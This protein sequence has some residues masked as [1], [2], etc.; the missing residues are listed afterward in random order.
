[1]PAGLPAGTSPDTTSDLAEGIAVIGMAGRFPGAP[2]LAAFWHNLRTGVESVRRLDASE[3]EESPFAPRLRAHPDFV[4]AGGILEGADLFDHG[5]FGLSP[6]EARLTDPQQRVF[7][8]LAWA[9]LEDAGIDPGRSGDRISVYA[10]ASHSGHL[11]GLLGELGGAPPHGPQPAGPA[12]LDPAALY[13]AMNNATAEN[14]ATRVAFELRLRGEAV[15]LYTACSTGLAVV[16]AACQSLLLGQ[17][18]VALAGAVRIAVPQ[19]TGYA[20]QEGMILSRD[21]HCRAFDA[22]ASGTV[23]GNGAGVVVLKPVEAALAAGDH[24]Y[25]VIKATAINNDGHRGIGFTAPSVAGQA[26]VISEAMAFAGVTGDDIGYVEAHGTGTPLGDPIEIAA[27]TRA[28]RTGSARTA[29]CPI[30]TVKSNVGH[31]DTAAG[32]AGLIKVALMLHHGEIPPT[33]HVR[34]PN[35]AAGFTGSP[36]FPVTDLRPWPAGKPRRAAVSS[37]GIGGTNVHAILEQAPDRAP[38]APTSRPYHLVTLAARTPQALDAM[39]GQLADYAE[40]RLEAG[41]GHLAD[42]A[43]TRVTGRAELPHRRT[44]VA[45]DLPELV[46][47]LRRKVKGTEAAPDPRVVLLFPGQGSASHG[48]AAG[49]YGAEP[50]F[51]EELEHVLGFLDPHLDGPLLPVLLEGSGPVLDPVQ[52]HAGLFAVEYALA[53]LWIRL[54]VQPYAVLGHSFGEYAAACVAGAWPLADA[55]RL[56]VLRGRL[57][58]RMPEGAMLAVAADEAETRSYLEGGL[59]LAAVNGDGRC[60]VSGPPATIAALSD[61]LET[62]GVARVPLAVRHA[63]HSSDVDAVLDELRATFEG[64][65]FTGPAIG[66]VSS[67]SGRW[68]GEAD[69]TPEYWARQMR[70][71]VRFGDALGTLT[72]AGATVFLETG[73]DQALASLA[74]AQVGRSIPVAAS[75]PRQGASG[76]DHRT[77]LEAAGTLWRTGVPLDWQRFYAFETRQRVPLPAYPFEHEHEQ[78]PPAVPPETVVD[79]VE[80]KVLVIWQERLGTRDF[81]IHDNFLELGG[82]SLMA[83]QMLTRLRETFAVELPLSALFEAPTVAAVAQQIRALQG[84]VS[85]VDDRGGLPGPQRLGPQAGSQAGSQAAPVLSVAQQRT[86]ALEAA[87]PGNPALLMPVAVSIDGPL[88]VGILRSAIARLAQRHDT[89]RTTYH[90]EGTAWTARLAD[91]PPVLTVEHGGGTDLAQVARAEASRPINLAQSPVRLRLIRTGPDRHTLLVTLHHVISDTWS[92]LVF[93]RDLAAF[94]DGRDPG[95]LPVQYHDFAAW[96]RRNLSGGALAGQ[97]A[98]WQE[99][100]RDAP[101]PPCLP[102]DRSRALEAGCRGFRVPVDLP[103]DLSRRIHEV[104]QRAKLTPFAAILSG[105]A[106]LLARISGVDDVVVGTPIGN[107]ERPELQPL[108]GYVAHCVPLRVTM[109]DDPTFWELAQRVMHTLYAT[110]RNPDVPY[111]HLVPANSGRLFPSASFVLHTE[112]DEELTVSGMT[113]RQLRV[114]DLPAEFGATLSPLTLML[115]ERD[116]GFDGAFEAA[117]ELFTEQTARRLAEQLYELL[118]AAT[119]KPHLPMSQW[120]LALAGGVL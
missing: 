40:G 108:I 43:F 85:R 17:S 26:E 42:I 65:T 102:T 88:D 119:R 59:A 86:L 3:L 44:A 21:G 35:P 100:L 18:A 64:C 110:Y 79:E 31:L 8:E 98:F 36:F 48:M 25:A 68:W 87:D 5:L 11:L 61:R 27:L 6:R 116:G 34:Q 20:Y 39:A 29:D 19:R 77:Q 109:S 89:L 14:L 32:I 52:S 118:D 57:V 54:G 38:A 73:P 83:A 10:G 4:P 55:A 12:P 63:F 95:P 28:Y 93:V 30:G 72:E 53:R 103:A 97:L 49:L 106:A 91:Q 78:A 41:P 60:V 81:G 99:V 113:W 51:R 9:A 66:L 82:N 75:L 45:A 76:S 16:H 13:E 120:D 70:E 22:S 23:P 2:D 58:S 114:P 84:Q 67:L 80:A 7:L 92:V 46:S 69:G 47:L 24:I 1:M 96:Q 105:Y 56:S 62:A 33:L 107:R 112:L 90:L 117:A 50:M 71:P 104:C 115:A 37:F 74:R 15:T 101:P 111:E 94:Y